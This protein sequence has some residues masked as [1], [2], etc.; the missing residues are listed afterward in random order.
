M[1]HRRL[2]VL[3]VSILLLGVAFVA[4]QQRDGGDMVARIRT[5]GLQRSS[6][7][8]LYRTL[9]DE[10]GARLTGSPSHVQAAR[11]ARDRFTEWGLTN[12]HLEP[13]AFGR[14]WQLEHISVAM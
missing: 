7:L 11:C 13:F 9:T 1:M 10:I 2:T 8:A 5:E 12:P 14:G 3:L 4:G 6:A